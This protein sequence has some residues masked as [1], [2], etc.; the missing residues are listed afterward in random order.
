[1]TKQRF[2][3]LMDS[4]PHCAQRGLRR[5]GGKTKRAIPDR[6]LAE[7]MARLAT[8]EQGRFVRAYR[9][10]FVSPAIGEHWHLTTRRA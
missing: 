3:E 6:P 9:C 8:V 7:V 10:D 2:D 1:M 5:H 4:F